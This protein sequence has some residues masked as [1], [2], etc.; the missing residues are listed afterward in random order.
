MS[1]CVYPPLMSCTSFQLFLVLVVTRCLFFYLCPLLFRSE[2]AVIPKRIV[3][4]IFSYRKRK[5][6]GYL[7]YSHDSCYNNFK[8]I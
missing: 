2:L 1:R 4:E 7:Q 5:R 8:K 3:G 6:T